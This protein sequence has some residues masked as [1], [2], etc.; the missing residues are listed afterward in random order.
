MCGIVGIAHQEVGRINKDLVRRMCGLLARRGPDGEGY[1]FD[2]CVGLGMR[3]LAIIDVQAGQQPISN[4]SQSIW[5]VFNGE[6]YNYRELR[7]DLERRNHHFATSSDTECLVHLYEDFGDEVVSRL[8]GMF[9]FAIWDTKERRLLLARDRLGIK[10]LYY[11]HAESRLAF[12]SEMKALLA[13]DGLERRMNLAALSHFFTLGY[14]PGPNTIY[15]SIYELPPA[16][17]AVWQDGRFWLRRYWEIRPEPDNGKSEQFFVEGL[18]HHLREAVDLHLMSEVPLGAFLSGG[19]DSSAV[20]ALM[21]QASDRKIKTF[22]VGFTSGERG[23]DERPFA[24]MVAERFSTEHTELLLNPNVADVLPDLVQAFDEPFADSSMIPNYLICR[25]AR[26]WVT[27]ALSGIGGDE[28]FAGYDRYRGALFAEYYRQVPRVARR[29]LIEPAIA[30]MS[31]SFHNGIWRDRFERFV[32]GAELPLADRYQSYITA[33]DDAEKVELFS[34]DLQA[35]L[36]RRGVSHT[37]LAMNQSV[38]TF[39]PLD[40]MLFTD[41]RMYLPDDELRK[42]DRI[43]MWHSLE[44]RVPFLDHKLVEFVATIPARYKLK[45]W[46]K[47]YALI[48]AL[49]GTLPNAILARRKQGFSIPLATWLR[50]P[51]R[52][53][54]HTYLNESALRDVGLLNPKTVIRLLTEHDRGISNHETQIWVLLIFMLWH[55]LYI[56][57]R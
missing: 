24:R 30:A 39:A 31:A 1:Y 11:S 37:P 9:A 42:I 26:D 21:A 45:M 17:I 38:Q 35:E 41:L 3:R 55:D 48:R 19:I 4:E 33:Y 34:D 46:K 52:D 43:S 32:Q 20:V 6:L 16:H 15:D 2:D 8:R 13:L 27:V 36:K 44:V 47:K 49:S 14:V 54:V 5:V 56:R 40:R 29:F 12:A 53:F 18:V 50:A 7:R 10:P 25:A 22:T 57:N 28:L 23:F 51:L